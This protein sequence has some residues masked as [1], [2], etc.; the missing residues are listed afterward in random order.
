MIILNKPDRFNEWGADMPY[1]NIGDVNIYY[2]E[3]GAG[4]PVIFLHSSFSRGVLSFAAQISAFHS[5]FRCFYPDMRG[6]GRTESSSLAW[7]TPDLA[8]DIIVF[9]DAL[10]I[11]QAHL[12]GFSLGGD[13]AL[14]AALGYR[15]RIKSKVIIG[16]T[17]YVTERT[18]N[19]A[20]QYQPERLIAEGKDA[21]IEFIK[22]NHQEAHQG[23][24]RKF[25][26]VSIQNWLSY[27]NLSLGDMR[28]MGPPLAFIFGENDKYVGARDRQILA[29]NIPQIPIHTIPGAGHAVHLEGGQPE[30]VNR[31]ILE[32]L[33]NSP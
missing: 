8:D 7:T 16:T 18:R 25:I 4:E 22:Q 31:I 21:L 27:P 1:L 29:R 10:G 28:A 17:Y 9:M 23:D 2:E 13:V 15:E 14:Y 32:I 19:M 26:E 5:K 33:K 24:W 20:A 6:H 30:Q 3:F 12:V 11:P